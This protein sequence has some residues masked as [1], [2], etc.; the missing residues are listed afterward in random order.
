VERFAWVAR[1]VL[2]LKVV[3]RGNEI[4]IGR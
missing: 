3:D 4:V 1:D 2:G